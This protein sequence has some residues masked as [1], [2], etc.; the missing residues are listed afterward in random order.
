MM[1][2]VSCLASRSFIF[3]KHYA[4]ERNRTVCLVTDSRK[5]A[6]WPESILPRLRRATNARIRRIAKP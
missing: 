1:M 2:D 3:E 5:A 6:E 4:G